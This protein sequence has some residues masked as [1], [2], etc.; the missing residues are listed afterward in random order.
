MSRIQLVSLSAVRC[1]DVVTHCNGS[2]CQ[3]STRQLFSPHIGIVSDH[4]RIVADLSTRPERQKTSPP[5]VRSCK[6]VDS[7]TVAGCPL[8]PPSSKTAD[9]LFSEPNMTEYWMTRLVPS[10]GVKLAFHDADTDN[11]FLARILAD[12][13]DTRN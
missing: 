7:E 9:E 4:S 12:T 3:R 6:S 5:T 13:S 10:R 8:A 2:D 1:R 11:D